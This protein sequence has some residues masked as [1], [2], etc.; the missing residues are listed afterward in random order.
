MSYLP[1]PYEAPPQD[2]LSATLAAI[3]TTTVALITSWVLGAR[4]YPVVREF[5]DGLLGNLT[6]AQRQAFT[7][8]LATQAVPT[9]GWSVAA[10]LLAIG[11]VL[12]LFRRG[13]QLLIFGALIGVATTAWAQFGIGYGDVGSGAA[14][15]VEQWPLYWGG[16]AVIVLAVLPATGR[17]LGRTKVP[18]RAGKPPGVTGTTESGAILWPGM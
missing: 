8:T 18:P 7:D 5:V 6:D 9:V 4:A 17:W 3:L 2:D 15:P 1:A 10:V 16:V 12:L 13:R 14:V 11:A